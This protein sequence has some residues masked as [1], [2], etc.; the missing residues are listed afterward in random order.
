VFSFFVFVF[1]GFRGLLCHKIKQQSKSEQEITKAVKGQLKTDL[2][3]F[4]VKL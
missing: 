3:K 2:I 4:I 1:N